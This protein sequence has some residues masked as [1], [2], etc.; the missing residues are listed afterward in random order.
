M[1]STVAGAAWRFGFVLFAAAGSLFAGT[2][3][4][5]HA[6][7]T[8]SG[9]TVTCTGPSPGGFDAGGQNGLTVTVQ[10]GATV[11]TGLS[12]ND[13]NITSNLG[14]ISVG[15]GVSGIVTGVNNQ[16]TSSGIITGGVNATAIF[17]NSGARVTNSG[18]LTVGDGGGGIVL[19]G[20][21]APAARASSARP[22]SAP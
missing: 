8:Q 11:G 13:N 9:T 16:I 20:T 6:D 18:T 4:P 15:N 21:G 10:P 2:A 17:A 12:L 14:T 3:G 22:I 7:C 19:A 1:R 5:A